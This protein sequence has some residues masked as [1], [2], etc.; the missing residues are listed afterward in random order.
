MSEVINSKIS[1]LGL[2]IS[3]KDTAFYT[4]IIASF[5]TCV[6]GRFTL[7]GL[8]PKWPPNIFFDLWQYDIPK[9]KK[10]YKLCR[11][12]TKEKL[13]RYDFCASAYFTEKCIVV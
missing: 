13:S 4:N 9:I 12:N 2:F 7:H 11:F 10:V 8:S 3:K 1:Y 6:T 5:A